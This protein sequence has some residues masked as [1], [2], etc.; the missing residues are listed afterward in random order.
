MTPPDAPGRD[1]SA[2]ARIHLASQGFIWPRESL[3]RLLQFD[4]L[5]LS[6]PW[7]KVNA[8]EELGACIE[9][10]DLPIALGGERP[11]RRERR[12]VSMTESRREIAKRGK[13][14]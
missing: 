9:F 4:A 1:S 12:D 10:Q 11:Q 7:V 13:L 14:E 2:V 3:G 6:Y 8:P 5:A